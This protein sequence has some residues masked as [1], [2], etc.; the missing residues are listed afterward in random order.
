MGTSRSSKKNDTWVAGAFVYSGRPDP[1]WNI[2]KQVAVK[3]QELW[4][5]LAATDKKYEPRPGG[6]G[7]RGV[8]VKEPGHR[9]WTAFNGTVS[10]TTPGGVEVRRDPARQFEK[11]LLS[12]APKGL[13][14][15]GILEREWRRL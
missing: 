1:A 8:F 2:S 7:Y 5:S 3:V 9:E 14:P 4:E 6:L 10:L 11:T 12:S 15:E 13:L